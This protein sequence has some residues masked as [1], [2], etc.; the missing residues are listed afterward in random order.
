MV[1][2]T[3]LSYFISINSLAIKTAAYLNRSHMIKLLIYI[4]VN[5][6]AKEGN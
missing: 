2:F 3:S 4:I 5:S 1:F 6:A